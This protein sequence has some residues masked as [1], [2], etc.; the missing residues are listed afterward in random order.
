LRRIE[1]NVSPAERPTLLIVAYDE[2]EA[3]RKLVKAREAGLAGE[4]TIVLTGV[5]RPEYNT[6]GAMLHRIAEH[7]R[8]ITDPR[9]ETAHS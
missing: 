1:A 3:D 2:R 9:P 7:G 6:I 4:P 5:P 8:K